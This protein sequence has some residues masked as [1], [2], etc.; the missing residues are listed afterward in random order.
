M[1]V[2]F[3]A[4]AYS[5]A[6]E[7]YDKATSRLW[8]FVGLN[9]YVHNSIFQAINHDNDGGAIFMSKNSAVLKVESCYFVI[10]GGA[11]I[12][13]CIYFRGD[14]I[15]MK[16]IVA[17]HISAVYN[18]LFCYVVTPNTAIDSTISGVS[19]LGCSQPNA[20]DLIT[21]DG[22]K[23]LVSYFNATLN[24]VRFGS[25]INFLY[26]TDSELKYSCFN[27]NTATNYGCILFNIKGKI[28]G[29]VIVNNDQNAKA[30]SGLIIGEI[31][32]TECTILS[33][34]GLLFT[35]GKKDITE[36]FIDIP[37]G[38]NYS[39]IPKRTESALPIKTSTPWLYIACGL[40]VLCIG[41][42]LF[43]VFRKKEKFD[44]GFISIN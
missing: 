38:E 36:S 15:T 8:N 2:L 20:N 16:T 17:K 1:F 18:S 19:V 22:G 41:L 30:T 10:C 4:L 34:T 24:L 28:E 9:V 6:V 44:S 7:E 3:L 27:S 14:K 25:G 13:G 12:G 31:V 37:S 23:K 32:L 35:G 11:G 42:V 40:A 39:I 5:E 29:T 43:I 26:S 21:L 33:N